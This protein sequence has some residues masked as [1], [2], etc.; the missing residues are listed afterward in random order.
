MAEY[1]GRITAMTAAGSA[2]VGA[3]GTSAVAEPPM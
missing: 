1:A 3:L 2:D